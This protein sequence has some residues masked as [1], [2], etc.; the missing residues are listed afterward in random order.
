MRR[1]HGKLVLDLGELRAD[2]VERIDVGWPS[3][4][5]RSLI[6]IDTPGIES[7]SRDVSARSAAFLTP[8]NAPS[9]AD[10]IVYLLRHLHPSDLKFLEA[11]RDTAAGASQTVNAV[12]VLSRADE[13]GSGRIDSLLSARRVA[14]AA[15]NSTAIW[16]RWLWRCCPSRV[17]W[18]R[19]PRT[20]REDEFAA[21]RA[22]A[23]LE[24][25]ERE[26]L[27]VSADRFT[28]P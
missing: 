4:D 16:P 17:C 5:L 7:L 12:A 6:L 20:L 24:R 19:A 27:L 8:D 1:D 22:L 2:E 15:T 13:I 21:F 26:R 23:D 18:P 9:S 14:D 11:F 3:R 10:A 25:G 28:A